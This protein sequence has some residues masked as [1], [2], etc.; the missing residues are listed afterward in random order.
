MKPQPQ[1]VDKY[2][3]S[4]RQADLTFTL[5]DGLKFHDGTPVTAEDVVASIQRWGARRRRPALM[6]LVDRTR[7]GRRQDLQDGA[8]GALRPGA[9]IAR[10]E[11]QLDRRSSCARR[12]RETD[13][14]QQIKESIG[15][16][17]FIFAKDQW[18]PGSKAVYVKNTDYVPRTERAVGLR[19]RQDRRGRPRRAGL[20]LR[21]ADLDVGADQR[22]DRLLREPPASTSCR[23]S[24]GASGVEADEDRQPTARRASSGSTTCIRRSTT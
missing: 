5:R 17:P 2:E 14:Q 6:A 15:S 23:S 10:Q 3:I 16:G 7:S 19:R 18:V 13:P 12:M 4:R 11:R 21:S 22:R 8:E 1:M 20:D 24:R 9:R